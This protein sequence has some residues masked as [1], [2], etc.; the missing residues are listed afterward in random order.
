[1]EN[2]KKQ[3]ITIPTA[4]IAAGFLIMVGL[5]LT[6]GINSGVSNKD[7]T[8]SEQVGVKKT[9]FAACMEKTDLQALK[10][11]TDASAELAMKGLPLEQR[12][13]PYS[14][15]VGKN[16]VK[17]EI[18]GAYPKEEVQKLIAEVNSGK[19]TTPYTGEIPGYEEGD[20]I[21]GSPDAQ[22]VIIEYADLECPYCKKFGKI[23]KEIVAE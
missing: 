9:A 23:M 17:T 22:I 16:G 2:T 12:G 20:H 1:M 13:T 19:V 11:T 6:G 18:R 15:I 7:K 10:T 21:I 5:L 4:I 8:L 14:V 3:A